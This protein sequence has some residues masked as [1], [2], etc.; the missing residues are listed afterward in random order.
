MVTGIKPTLLTDPASARPRSSARRLFLNVM[1]W[2]A[3]KRDSALRLAEIRRLRSIETSSFNVRSRCSSIR[4]S[5]HCEYFSKGDVPPPRGIGSHVP[6]SRKRCSHRIAE[7]ALTS[8]CSAASRRDPP[9][10]TNSISELSSSQDTVPALVGPLA[11]QALDSL[12]RCPL[13]IP[14]HSRWDAL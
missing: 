11:N 10:S 2:R 9:A 14:I 6:S 3:K 4:A 12:R 1:S 5:I 8:K 7:L 13:G